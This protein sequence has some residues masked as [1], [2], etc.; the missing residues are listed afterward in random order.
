MSEQKYR[1]NTDLLRPAEGTKC[2]PRMVHDPYP[3]VIDWGMPEDVNAGDFTFSVL[4]AAL[5]A[6]A[7]EIQLTPLDTLGEVNVHFR[8]GSD[9]IGQ[10]PL[11]QIQFGYI[12]ILLAHIATLSRYDREPPNSI[13]YFH[14]PD[15]RPY[16]VRFSKTRVGD[17]ATAILIRLFMAKEGM[18]SATQSP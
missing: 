13:R 1:P 7:T 9:F 17:H 12:A 2:E 16:Y 8:I 4:E 18:E 11:T 10:K 5:G 3:R 14:T 15:H 6:G